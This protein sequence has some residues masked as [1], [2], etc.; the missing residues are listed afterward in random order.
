MDAPPTEP[1]VSP[2][3]VRRFV[4][5]M[6]N[7]S[8]AFMVRF[9]APDRVPPQTAS[10][11]ENILQ[12][13]LLEPALIDTFPMD[14]QTIAA[15]V[16]PRSGQPF[17]PFFIHSVLML[18]RSN[19]ALDQPLSE[20]GPPAQDPVIVPLTYASSISTVQQNIAELNELLE[21]L[22]QDRLCVQFQPIV[23]L[24]S[25]R[26][27]G[28]EALI[29][30]PKNAILNKPGALFKTADKARLVSWLDVACQ[31]KCFEEAARHDVHEKLFVNMDA[32]GLAFLHLADRSLA[33]AAH[34]VGIS[35]RNVVLE[36]TER[37]A[38]D[39]FPRLLEYVEWLRAQG[40][41]LAIDDAGNGYSSLE[42]I[43][44][45]RPDY[46]KVERS[47][48]RSL[49]NSGMRRALLGALACLADHIGTAIVAEGIETR[50]ELAAVIDAGVAYGQGY[51][52][53]RPN[54]LFK[55][56][57]KSVQQVLRQRYEHVRHRTTGRPYPVREIARSGITVPR[58]APLSE[59]AR[60]FAKDAD[61]TCIVVLDDVHVAG[62]ITRDKMESA[63]LSG[64]A[65][66][67]TA[68]S[69]MDPQPVTIPAHLP[70][71][72]VPHRISYLPEGRFGGDL[73]VTEQDQYVGV[74]PVRDLMA[75][76]ATLKTNHARH[77]SPLTG[78]PGK[79]VSE[80]EAKRRIQS[81]E[82][83]VLLIT[84]VDHFADFNEVYGLARGDE[85]IC[86][87]A[88]LLEK[89]LC[90]LQMTGGFLGHLGADHFLI[91]APPEAARSFALLAVGEFKAL[92][93]RLQPRRTDRVCSGD[94]GSR[95][96]IPPLALKI[97]GVEMFGDP[98][99][100]CREINRLI[101]EA[102]RAASDARI[103]IVR[104]SAIRQRAA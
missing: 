1:L 76:I 96:P 66:T 25:A 8:M 55:P 2:E 5:R 104:A 103:T 14:A 52:L 68:A 90:S 37:Q 30:G 58:E 83:L 91:L 36:I 89:V 49:R 6:Q 85:V 79:A 31:Q 44:E 53:G 24:A 7:C 28:Y 11:I 12:G 80:H 42:A 62:I 48:V 43:A 74:L 97:R 69:L 27:H 94:E 21:T 65:E 73:V 3:P 9:S 33:A 87:L 93:P 95:D 78:L 75:A 84:E 46:I 15:V 16:T 54:D 102:R 29:R 92:G 86:E 100:T 41:M 34:E 81:G 23:D 22:L 32:E 71:D 13:I 20:T 51:Y 10:L 56:L 17:D 98:G 39:D 26:I 38:V 40:F 64:V 4:D 72:E 82:A 88:K 60:K 19:L 47:L 99:I 35:P 57:R 59:V 101:R 70:V 67:A 50:D 61:L 45:M 63:A 77:I 18:L